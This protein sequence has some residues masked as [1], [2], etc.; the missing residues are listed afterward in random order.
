MKLAL[1]PSLV[2]GVAAIAA[3]GAG[4]ATLHGSW[5]QASNGVE[6]VLAPKFKLQPNYGLSTGTNLGGSVGAYSATRTTIVTEPMPM[7]VKRTMALSIGADGRFTWTTEK[8]HAETPGGSCIKTTRTERVGT[9]AQSGGGLTFDIAGG[10]ESW[11]KSC[12]GAGSAPVAASREAY[13]V[14][15]QGS[16]LRLADGPHVWLFKRGS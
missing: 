15:I 13:Q 6:V 9:V 8:S 11:R 3:A 12:G 7:P 1:I 2:L 10:T 14:S 4:G 16:S 5:T